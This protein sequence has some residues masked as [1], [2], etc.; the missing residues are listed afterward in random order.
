[1]IYC[2]PISLKVLLREIKLNVHAP[3][4]FSSNKETFGIATSICQIYL[5]LIAN[6][7]KNCNHESNHDYD[8]FC[9]IIEWHYFTLLTNVIEYESTVTTAE[10]NYST[11]E[12]SASFPQLHQANPSPLHPFDPLMS[13]HC[14]PPLREEVVS[15]VGEECAGAFVAP[16][17][18]RSGTGSPTHG[19][20]PVIFRMSDISLNGDFK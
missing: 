6:M 18:S 20:E 19:S 7:N 10:Y 11:S 15:L 4:I 13:H 1:M 16:T 5:L 12:L 14:L 17:Q 3:E 2:P 8:S 9:N